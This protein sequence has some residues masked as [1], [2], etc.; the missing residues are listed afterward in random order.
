[1]SRKKRIRDAGLLRHVMSRG[2]GRMQIF[3]DEGDYR[4][5]LFVLAYVLESYQV[6]C[7]AFCLMPNHYHLLLRNQQ[8]NLAEAMRDLNGEYGFW[9]NANHQRVGHVFQRRYKDQIVQREGYFLNLV[10][11]V[12]VNPVRAK[13]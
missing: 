12:A 6:E 4:K 3:L 13:L 11:Y 9:W 8:R 2:N 7:W 1:M 10:R 5:F